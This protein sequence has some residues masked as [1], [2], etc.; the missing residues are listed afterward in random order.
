MPIVALHHVQLAMPVDGEDKARDFYA[1]A[2]G[3]TEVAKPVNLRKR[4]GCWF[5]AGSV[6]IHLGVEPGFRPA[7]KAHPAFEVEDLAGLARRLAQAGYPTRPDEPL[8]GF[9]RLYVDDPFG[10][11]IE[12]LEAVGA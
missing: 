8:P 7:K 11:R 12:L 2:L 10:N 4:G 1:R 3:L 6:R 9:N 5:E